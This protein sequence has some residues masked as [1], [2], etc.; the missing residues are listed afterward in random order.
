MVRVGLARRRMPPHAAGFRTQKE[1]GSLGGFTWHAL[2][3]FLSLASPKFV[4]GGTHDLSTVEFLRRLLNLLR[5]RLAA[6]D[7][8]HVAHHVGIHAGHGTPCRPPFDPAYHPWRPAPLRGLC[9]ISYDTTTFST[10]GKR[11]RYQSELGLSE[12]DASALADDQSVA[13][14]FEEAVAAGADPG[15]ACKWLIGDIAGYLNRYVQP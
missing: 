2:F 10:A 7:E 12:G 13:L 11:E 1:Q 8:P 9:V 14:Y 5:L 3:V 4:D 6:Y 15:E